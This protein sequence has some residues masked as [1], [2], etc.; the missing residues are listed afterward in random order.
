[1]TGQGSVRTLVVGGSGGIGRACVLRLAAMSSEMWIHGGHDGAKLDATI[2]QVRNDYPRMVVHGIL[3]EFHGLEDFDG[4]LPDA[5]LPD[6][7]VVAWGPLQESS[8]SDMTPAEWEHIVLANLAL[9][10]WLAGKY[11]ASM[12]RRGGGTLVFFG[13]TGSMDPRAYREIPAYG[14]AKT[15][16]GVVVRSA[17]KEF[18]G[19]GVNVFAIHPGHVA[20]EYL[21]RRQ[22]ET[23]GRRQV[24]GLQ[25]PDDIGRLVAWLAGSRESSVMSGTLVSAE[26]MVC[27][28]PESI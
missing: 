21:D 6:V 11:G 24:G 2:A 7:V 3:R 25:S 1:M 9:P 18:S 10:G 16:L 15:G 8:M 5:D 13:G 26:G 12:A 22:R 28:E 17:A 27:P 23:W 19:H 14:A 4:A 20:T